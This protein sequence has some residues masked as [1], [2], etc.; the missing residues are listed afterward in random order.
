MKGLSG[1]QFCDMMG[2][3]MDA[4][5]NIKVFTPNH[6]YISQDCTHLTEDGAKYYTVILD[7][8]RIFK[9]K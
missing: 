1:G 6:K 7:L 8:D 5:G 3:V 4:T 2:P 9:K